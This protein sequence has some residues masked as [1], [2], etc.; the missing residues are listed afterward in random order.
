MAIATISDAH[1]FGQAVRAARKERELSQRALADR[2]GCSQ[3][4]I[5]ELERGKA[6]AELGKAL[7]VL[8]ELGLTLV[9]RREHPSGDAQEA[10]E[11]LAASVSERLARR[12]RAKAS[13]SEFL[14]E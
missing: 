14:G 5:S 8:E 1:T 4:F 3:R 10:V 11:R 12:A 6:T 2:C 13:L 7:W 9:V